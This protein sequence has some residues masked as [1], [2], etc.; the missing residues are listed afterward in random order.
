LRQTVKSQKSL[1]G[2]L[3]DGIVSTEVHEG[4]KTGSD[5]AVGERIV[6]GRGGASVRNQRELA[7]P[8]EEG[9]SERPGQ[10]V[11]GFRKAAVG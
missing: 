2:D 9:V 4:S 11:S 3:T 10:C 1:N 7:A 5:T 6:G 8:M